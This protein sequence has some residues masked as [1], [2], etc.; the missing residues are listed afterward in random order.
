[1]KR[2]PLLF[3]LS[4]C[5]GLCHGQDHITD[6]IYMKNGGA[7]FTLDVF[8]VAAPNAPCVIWLVSGGWISNHEGINP[9]IAKLFNDQGIAVVEVVHGSQP[10]YTLNDI[11]PQ[12]KRAVRYVHANASR[13]G[14]DPNRIGI[15]G[16]SAGGH[17][18]LMIGGIGNAGDPN[19]TDQIEKFPSSVNAV[20]VFMP[21]TDF[22]NWGKGGNLPFGEPQMTIFMPA[23]GVTKDTPKEKAI[24]V[25]RIMSPIN[26]V[27]AKFPP[28]MIIHGDSDKLVPIQQ[29]AIMD[30]ALG[31]QGIDHTFITIPGG[32]HD[33]KTITEGFPKLISWFKAKLK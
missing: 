27:N 3:L 15:S 6:Q 12:I 1:M 8:K 14:V 9:I 32:G 24:E 29:A 19:A 18:S 5:A 10:R 7:A 33:A 17:L 22:L 26:Y 28:T 16:A 21:P 13:F 31:K 23:F 30:A 20:G 11:V 4:L 2:T 25:G